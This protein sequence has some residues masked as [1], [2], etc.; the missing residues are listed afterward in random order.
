MMS[1]W[2]HRWIACVC[3]LFLGFL[4]GSCKNISVVFV[5]NSQL[6]VGGTETEVHTAQ[7]E[8]NN[9]ILASSRRLVNQGAAKNSVRKNKNSAPARGSFLSPRFFLI[10]SRAVFY[11]AP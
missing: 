10:F 2:N 8:N 11:A 9:V 7:C 1:A 4:S 3:V 5:L 6:K